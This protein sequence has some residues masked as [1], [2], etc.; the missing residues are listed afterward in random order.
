MFFRS[1]FYEISLLHVKLRN[2]R[3]YKI[4]FMDEVISDFS[5]KTH[6]I[7][8]SKS[9]YHKRKPKKLILHFN[10]KPVLF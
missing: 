1:M 6:V 10:S 8:L 3:T 2:E 5:I 7:H 9:L 4:N